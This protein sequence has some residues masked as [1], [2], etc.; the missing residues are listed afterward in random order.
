MLPRGV[1][2]IRRSDIDKGYGESKSDEEPKDASKRWL[3]SQ[4]GRLGVSFEDLVDKDSALVKGGRIHSLNGEAAM[5]HWNFIEDEF[6]LHH[7]IYTGRVTKDKNKGR[8]AYS[9]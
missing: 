5:D 2:G 4:C 7:A 1:T 9:G 6:W 8:F 3:M